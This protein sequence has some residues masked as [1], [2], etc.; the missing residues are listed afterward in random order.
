MLRRAHDVTGTGFVVLDRIYADGRPAVEALGGSCGNVLLS[1]AMLSVKVTPILA[2]GNDDVGHR[3]V[4]QFADAGACTQY[5]RRCD[6]HASPI[7]AQIL[8]TTLGQHSFSFICPDTD[9]PLPRYQPINDE[10]VAPAREALQSSCVFYVD[11][12][13]RPIVEAME[14]AA[15]AGSL[16]Y[17]EPSSI[18]DRDLFTRAVSAASILKFSSDCL[19]DE[20]NGIAIGEDKVAIVTHGARGLEIR[21][22]RHSFFSDAFAAPQVVDTCGSGDMVSVG[23]IDHIVSTRSIWAELAIEMLLDGVRAGQRLAAANC[24]YA[25]ARGVFRHHGAA[26]ARS[27]MD[28]SAGTSWHRQLDLFPVPTKSYSAATR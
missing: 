24:A 8:D 22:G 28:G 14:C 19:H 25:G 16:V 17:F 20:L 12:I 9:T 3:M 10:D 21:K 26:T 15:S 2:I 23:V 5:I 7:L 1:L 6:E 13:S 11:R 27:I 4:S 18:G